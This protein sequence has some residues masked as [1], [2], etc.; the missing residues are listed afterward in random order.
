MNTNT[1]LGVIIVLV[2]VGGVAYL[3][4]KIES[5]DTRGPSATT[6]PSATVPEKTTTKTSS[7]TAAKPTKTTVNTVGIGSLSYLLNL[8]QPLVCSIKTA[9]GVM[10][11]GTLYVVAGMARANF[12][13]STMIDDSNYLYAWTTSA[14][15]GIKLPAS[16]SVSGSVI[17]SRGGVDL[18]TDLS[19]SCSPWTMDAK[20]FVPPTSISF[21][22]N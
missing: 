14:A 1:I 10:R 17:A 5:E 15:T 20:I 4:L 11:S 16:S 8:R 13:N 12:T 18:A 3:T 2:L 9:S 22:E 7:Y 6:T 21:I 19:F